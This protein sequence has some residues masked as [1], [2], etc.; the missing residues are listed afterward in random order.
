MK[1]SWKLRSVLALALLQT[2]LGGFQL[3]A[4]KSAAEKCTTAIDGGCS[5]NGCGG[6][7]GQPLVQLE[8][9]ESVALD[10]CWCLS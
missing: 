5:N 10:S 1:L 8:T 9:G 6:V 4:Q 2:I 7:C 3:A